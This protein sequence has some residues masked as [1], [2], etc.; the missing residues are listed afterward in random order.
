MII[1]VAPLS[2]T[3]E[4]FTASERIFMLMNHELTHVA[5]MDAS[6]RTDRAWRTFFAGKPTVD[7]NHPETILYSYLVTPRVSVPRWYLEGSAVFMETWMSG[8][9]GR[10]QGA[11]DEMV[12]RSMV[13]DDAHFYSPLGLVSIG[14]HIDFQ[15]GVNAYLYGT[16]FFCYLGWAYSPEMVVQWL[17]RGEGS[18]RYYANQFKYVFGKKLE[19]V[20]QDWIVW[21]HQFQTE[22]LAA[23]EEFPITSTRPLADR[24]LGSISRSFVDLEKKEMVGAFRY[25]GKVAHIGR[26]SLDDGNIEHLADIK[27]PM[28][29]RVTA[30]AHD[31]QSNTYFYTADN[32]AFRD[33]MKI[34]AD[35]GE[36]K[37]LI[38]DA[39]IG[40]LVVNPS[41]RSI[42]GIRHLNGYATI[43]RIPSPHTSWNQVHTWPYGDVLYDMDISPDGT[44]LST[45]MGTIDGTQLLR[46]FSIDKLLAGNIEP[47]IELDFFGTAV[48]EGFVFSPDGRFLYGSSYYT[49]V[50]NIFRYEVATGELEAVSNTATGFFRPIPLEDGSLIVFE[51]TGQGFVPVIIDPIP[52]KDASSVRFL[53]A[54]LVKKHPQ[55]KQWEIS[56]TLGD[57][58][59]EDIK[60]TNDKYRPGRE[61]RLQS[62]YPVVE[63]Y[64]D[65]TAVGWHFNIEDTMAFRHLGITASYNT[66]TDLPTNERAHVN[67]DY[68]AINWRLGY[69]Y[70]GA[71]FYDLFGPTKRSRKGNAYTVGYEKALIYDAPRRLDYTAEF[72]YYTNLDTLPEFQNIAAPFDELLSGGLMLSYKNTRSSLG[73][74][75]Q[76]KGYSWEMVVTGDHANSET[77]PKW[78]AD[79][80]FGIALPISHSSIW[81]R[82]SAGGADGDRLDPLANF[83]FGGF[84]NNDVDDGNVKRYREYYSFPGFKIDELSGQTFVRSLF[85]WNLPPIRFRNMGTPGFF[86]AYAR[87][88]VFYGVLVT[89]PGNNVVERTVTTLGA[90][91]DF[92][93]TF[94]QRLDM[95]LS[96]GYAQGYESGNKLSDEWMVSLKLL[97]FDVL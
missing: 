4:T 9:L 26:M 43:V 80:D 46:V 68:R 97:A 90:Q 18:K 79:F 72:G 47:V 25:P 40:E 15:V 63:G 53:G 33:L 36:T 48:P 83:Y 39:R 73:G 10:A 64:R 34:D 35:S 32:H 94:A 86:L 52:V 37:M 57:V 24:A 50:S 84:G 87:P 62:A 42:W 78:R 3:F 71:D 60:H 44:L 92:Q 51:Y 58:A 12:F 82:S 69:K 56:S 70:N 95:T 76:E 61:M 13:R 41:D 75:D 28:L 20:W 6:S 8:G 2:R 49:G 38:R 5:T 81:L 45:S 16:R 31:R 89:D 85:E 1:D 11:Y 65:S 93:F 23:I 66:D 7:E 17:Q 77:V 96:V 21:E 88:A 55:I 27:G 91:L 67:I 59:F 19:E 74:V 14:T 30:L 54:E 29:Y 22:N